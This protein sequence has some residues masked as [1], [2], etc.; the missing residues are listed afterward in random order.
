MPQFYKMLIML[1]VTTYTLYMPSSYLLNPRF[2]DKTV[3]DLTGKDLRRQS[4]I[5][6][7][8][9]YIIILCKKIRV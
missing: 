6:L 3:C 5:T 7:T 1:Y 4:G 2:T 9:T 8:M